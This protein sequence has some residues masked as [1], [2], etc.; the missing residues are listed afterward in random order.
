MNTL[1]IL[2]KYDEDWR[3]IVKSFGGYD[4]VDDVVQNFYIKVHKTNNQKVVI[5][6]KPNKVYCWVTLRTLYI[7]EIKKQPCHNSLEEAYNIPDETT[8]DYILNIKEITED[9]IQNWHYYDRML[10]KIYTEQDLSMR[11]IAKE[12]NISLT[13]I[14]FSLK[15]CKTKLKKRIWHEEKKIQDLEIL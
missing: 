7:D 2:S 11:E 12:T 5:D 10:W 9:E 13:S 15:E 4:Y 8:N 3:R 14:F 1:E 6:G